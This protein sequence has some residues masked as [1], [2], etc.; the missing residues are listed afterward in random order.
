MQST[1]AYRSCGF[2]F[3]ALLTMV[4]RSPRSSRRS[5]S[6]VVPR[7]SA[8]SLLSFA[9]TASETRGGSS[10]EHSLYQFRGRVRT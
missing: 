4:S 10:V 3:K 7:L 5:L 6:E 2:F 9:V 1:E 8:M